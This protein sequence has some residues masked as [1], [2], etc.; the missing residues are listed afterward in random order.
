MTLPFHLVETIL[1]EPDYL[2]AAPAAVSPNGRYVLMNTYKGL[3]VLDRTDETYIA[4]FDPESLN[5]YI[6]MAIDDD[7]T[8]Y[9]V[10]APLFVGEADIL[11]Q[12][13][14]FGTG[15]LTVLSE[16][17]EVDDIAVARTLGLFILPDDSKHL[18]WAEDS[19]GGGVLRTYNIATLALSSVSNGG[20]VNFCQTVQDS[21]GDVWAIAPGV[22]EMVFQRIL[23]GGAGTAAPDYN[24]V[25]LTSNESG[26]QPT[27]YHTSEGWFVCY[28]GGAD[29]YLLDDVDF[30]TIAHRSYGTLGNPV[31]SPQY[32]QP[33]F[34]LC[35]A[36]GAEDFW[37]PGPVTFTSEF[38]VPSLGYVDLH[39]INAAD[40]TSLEERDI[41]DWEIGDTPAVNAGMVLTTHTRLAVFSMWEGE[42]TPTLRYFEDEDEETPPAQSLRLRVWGYRL[43]GHAHYCLRVG[44]SETLVYDLTT[45]QWASWKSPARD[46]WRAHVGQN[47]VGM[48][49]D[50]FANGFGS[51]VVAGDDATN[52]LWILDPTAGQDDNPSTGNPEPFTRMVAG[53]IPLDGREVAQCNAVTLDLS[54]GSPVLDGATITLETSDDKGKSWVDH[55]AVT[56]TADVNDD[57]VEW[58]G[59]GLMR[60]PGRIFRITDN[61][62][63]VRLGAA[64]M[65]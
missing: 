7:G 39:K 2:G 44:A 38:G 55:G 4:A 37:F 43:D 59:L 21:Y 13:D 51:D 22:D 33:P 45:K 23:D 15:D 1:D 35:L 24:T 58:R 64:D 11:H 19:I 28:N 46:N 53:G 12:I 14:N 29:L 27:A 10:R 48:S 42:L 65:R 26:I 63:T 52:V 5:S 41:T 32:D 8:L 34:L 47:W 16:A 3:W 56:I 6:G 20:T 57:V 49:S 9:A 62:A 50:T 54:L 25:A 31:N 17:G 60:A 40:L 36:P 61:G 18:V 30:S